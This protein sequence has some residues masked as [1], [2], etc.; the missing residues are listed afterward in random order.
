MYFGVKA[1]FKSLAL[2]VKSC[3]ALGNQK[4]LLN[5]DFLFQPMGIIP[6]NIYKGMVSIKERNMS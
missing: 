6:L 3:K 5:L 4:I 1:K 2:A